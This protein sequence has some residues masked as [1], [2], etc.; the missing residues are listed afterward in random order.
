MDPQLPHSWIP[1]SALRG[2]TKSSGLFDIGFSKETDTPTDDFSTINNFDLLSALDHDQD[3]PVNTIHNSATCAISSLLDFDDNS[4]F[5]EKF[6]DLTSFLFPDNEMPDVEAEIGMEEAHSGCKRKASSVIPNPDHSDYTTKRP[7][8]TSTDDDEPPHTKTEQKEK[9]YVE[10]RQKNNVASKRSRETRKQK[11]VDMEVKAQELEQE[12]KELAIRV[13]E[14]ELLTK[15]M[16]DILVKR[17][18]GAQ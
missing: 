13:K 15:T 9:K 5:N 1:C 14:M 10:R 11:Y 16:K 7:R 12:N 3:I 18:S 4:M 8:L 17:L 2:I 6:M